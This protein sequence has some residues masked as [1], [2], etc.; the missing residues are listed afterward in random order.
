MTAVLGVVALLA[1]ALRASSLLHV[2]TVSLQKKCE[3]SEIS[4]ISPLCLPGQGLVNAVEEEWKARVGCGLIQI[5]DRP[6]ATPFK[7][8]NFSAAEKLSLGRDRVLYSSFN[9]LPKV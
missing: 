4:E 3:K 9:P 2:L 5:R 6:V 7:N 8:L 1:A